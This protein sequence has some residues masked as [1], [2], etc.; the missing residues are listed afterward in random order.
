MVKVVVALPE[1]EK[2]RNPV[3]SRRVPVIK[4]L[5]AQVVAQTVDGERALLNGDN[6]ED[7][8]VDE[9]TLPIAPAKTCDQHG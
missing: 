1:T 7:T 2:G 3:V 5:I 9:S 4:G 6:T 8:R